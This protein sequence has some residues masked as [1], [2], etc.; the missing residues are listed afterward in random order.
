MRAKDFTLSGSG[1]K[2][3]SDFFERQHVPAERSDEE[4]DV[5][6][7]RTCKKSFDH[8]QRSAFLLRNRER[9]SVHGG[10]TGSCEGGVE[11]G[12]SLRGFGADTDLG[13]QRF[14]EVHRAKQFPDFV[15][16]L[17]FVRMM[18]ASAPGFKKAEERFFIFLTAE[19]V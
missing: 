15:F 18:N 10:R 1:K 2:V 5:G 12:L 14:F 4:K 3:A 17:L 13:Q 9:F 7:D 8:D 6:R 11:D 16:V 19:V